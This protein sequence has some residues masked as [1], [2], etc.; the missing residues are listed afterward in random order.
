M[1]KKVLIVL[2]ILIGIV[3]ANIIYNSLYKEKFIND[4]KELYNQALEYLKVHNDDKYQNKNDYQLFIAADNLAI[5]KNRKYQ[6]VY[7]WIMMQSCYV[8]DN[9]LVKVSSSSMIYKFTFKDGQIIKY[10]LPK[11]GA[12]YEKSIKKMIPK[13]LQKKVL[14]YD[15]PKLETAIEN[16]LKKHYSYLEEI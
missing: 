12:Y 13:S 3:L 7:M 10:T 1:K 2:S 9:E 6:F 14:N 5:T 4:N 16:D 15:N 11:D 8:N